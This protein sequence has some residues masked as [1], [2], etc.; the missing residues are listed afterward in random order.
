MIFDMTKYKYI[1]IFCLVRSYCI[2]YQAHFSIDFSC[3]LIPS[4]FVY[5]FTL[6]CFENLKKNYFYGK[7]YGKYDVCEVFEPSDNF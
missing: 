5:F 3:Q 7:L 6:G 4:C 2:S 1:A